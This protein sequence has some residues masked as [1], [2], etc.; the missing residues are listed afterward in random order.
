MLIPTATLQKMS[1]V[2]GGAS[3]LAGSEESSLAYL[4]NLGGWVEDWTQGGK[5]TYKQY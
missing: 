2:T 5:L 1:P 4:C 3:D